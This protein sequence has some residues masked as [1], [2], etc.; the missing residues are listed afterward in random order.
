MQDLNN[1]VNPKVLNQKDK[2]ISFK[3][4]IPG[5]LQKAMKKFVEEHP[6]MSQY[7][8]MEAAIS[9]FLMQKGFHNRHLTRLYLGN[10]Y[11]K[12]FKD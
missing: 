8:I 4:E 12:N 10:I 2:V 1:D 3:C 7:G 6:D 9:G 5:N 11:S